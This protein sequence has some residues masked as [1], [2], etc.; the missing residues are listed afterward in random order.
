LCDLI[1]LL[2]SEEAENRSRFE[3][4]PRRHEAYRTSPTQIIPKDYKFVRTAP[5][6]LRNNTNNNINNSPPTP[7]NDAI[8][9]R[10]SP[11][12]LPQSNLNNDTIDTTSSNISSS[13]NDTNSSSLKSSAGE[14]SSSTA[15]R[16]NTAKDPNSFAA[17]R[18][19]VELQ[20]QQINKRK[21]GEFRDNAIVSPKSPHINTSNST[22]SS[23]S[24]S[25]TTTTASSNNNSKKSTPLPQME[26]P[27]FH[28]QAVS[29]QTTTTTQSHSSSGK[30][31]KHSST[32]TSTISFFLFENLIL[33]V[34]D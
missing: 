23:T 7:S 32:F 14:T 25:N 34:L 33:K 28:L 30:S 11:T 20:L 21:S 26:I 15:L 12:P 13:Q 29:Q 19:S 17:K 10:Q 3:E 5:T 6:A 27:S 2:V 24:S 8:P 31:G 1:G 4:K 9:S 18:K 16:M 22:I